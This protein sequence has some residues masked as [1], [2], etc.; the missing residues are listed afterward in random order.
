MCIHPSFWSHRNNFHT[1]KK[2]HWYLLQDNSSSISSCL[3]RGFQY[4]GSERGLLTCFPDTDLTTAKSLM[5]ARGIKQLPVVKRGVAHRTAGKRRPI[6]LLHYDSIGCCVRLVI[7]SYM[8]ALCQ[9]FLFS[10]TCV[11]FLVL[12]SSMLIQ[13][14][15]FARQGR[16]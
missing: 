1:C 13:V 3:T 11:G 5:E 7:S 8:L 15:S 2:M 9:S 12:H 16:K 14:F 10:L 4:R 6:A